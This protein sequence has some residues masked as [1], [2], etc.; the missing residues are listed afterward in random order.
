MLRLDAILSHLGCT[1]PKCNAK[2]LVHAN[3]CQTFD[4]SKYSDNYFCA[5]Q[6][7]YRLC[8]LYHATPAFVLDISNSILLKC[9]A[10]EFMHKKGHRD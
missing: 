9:I 8:D 5:F 6:E 10:T 2:C 3:M 1:L 7:K 4:I